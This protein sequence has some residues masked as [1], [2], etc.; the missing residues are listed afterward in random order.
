[1]IKIYGASDDLIE[2][3]GDW[4]DEIAYAGDD[5]E[6][7]DWPTLALSDGTLL[8]VC[9]D[10]CWRFAVLIAGSVPFT[11]VDAEAE[12]KSGSRPDGTGWYSDVL[13]FDG[14][15]K[16]VAH[17]EVGKYAMKTPLRQRPR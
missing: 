10:G 3:V 8:R 13:T 6:S 11:R 5:G 12:E 7:N 16:W 2:I 17:A 15:I 9:Y 14:D 4:E 1:M